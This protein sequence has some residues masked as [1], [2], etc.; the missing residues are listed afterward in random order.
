M[1]FIKR[2]A[3]QLR[4]DAID[5]ALSDDSEGKFWKEI[6]KLSP[7]NVPLPVSI[8][9]AT[10]KQEVADMWKEHF[11]NLLNCVKG[12]NIGSL[13]TECEF[14]PSSVISPGEIEDAINKLV[15][16]NPVDWMVFMLSI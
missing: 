3:D 5:S 1:I 16:G 14:N 15:G 10:G 4:Q 9:D 13:I 12:K 8:D 7:N 6:K 2:H 11:K